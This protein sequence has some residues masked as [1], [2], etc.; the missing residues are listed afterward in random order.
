[1]ISETRGAQPGVGPSQIFSHQI[2]SLPSPTHPPYLRG[3]LAGF[4]ASPAF[5]KEPWKSWRAQGKRLCGLRTYNLVSK[6]TS[7]EVCGGQREPTWGH[8][9]LSQRGALLALTPPAQARRLTP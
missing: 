7:R 6:P 1:M 2:L 9:T 4:S 5:S 8:P 3:G